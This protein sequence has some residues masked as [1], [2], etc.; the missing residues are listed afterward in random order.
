M[1]AHKTGSRRRSWIGSRLALLALAF[2]GGGL[3]H[4]LSAQENPP[5]K[6][7]VRAGRLEE[8][9]G[10]VRMFRAYKIEQGQR[11]PVE[12]R[13]EPLQ[14]WNDPTRAFSDASLWVWGTTGRPIAALAVELYPVGRTKGERWG[15]EF[16]SLATG[17]IEVER[18]ERIEYHLTTY[19]PRM[20]G[21]LKWAPK[22]PGIEFGEIPGAPTPARIEV[23]RL[24][25]MKAL[26]PR[27]SA[28]EY[29][30]RTRQNYVLRLLP[31]PV[32][33]YADPGRGLVDGA[34]FL[35]VHGTNPEV[36][37]LIEAQEREPGSAT[38]R[39]AL[40]PLSRAELAVRFDE[41][42][43]WTRPSPLQLST[44]DPYF[45]VQTVRRPLADDPRP[46]T[47]EKP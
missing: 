15:H 31:H 47:G 21:T 3:A 44:E 2:V 9:S 42:E 24:R 26:A 32:L 14:R 36:L 23:E 35:F 41:K 33:R 28:R 39:Y 6:D 38:W 4:R 8:M 40:A 12:I 25:Q 27:F 11:V 18:S 5:R 46:E 22:G 13:P 29:Y 20:E 34:F 1:T 7:D 30:E 43:V 10:L 45:T 17:P 19:A 16:V 37:L